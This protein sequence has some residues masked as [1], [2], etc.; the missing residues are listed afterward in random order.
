MSPRPRPRFQPPWSPAFEGSAA[1]RAAGAQVQAAL[2]L[3]AERLLE[4]ASLG[5]RFVELRLEVRRPTK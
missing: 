4:P 3:L 5:S 1:G 2:V